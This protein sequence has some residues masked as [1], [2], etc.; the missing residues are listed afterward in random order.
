MSSYKFIKISPSDHAIVFKDGKIIKEGRG[1]RF[2]M[3]PSKQYVIIPA[4][5][6]NIAFQADQIT[7]ENQGVEVTGFAIWK[8]GNPSK[9]YHHFDF[10]SNSNSLEQVNIFLKD[11]VESAIRHMVANMSIEEVLRKRGTIILQLKKELEYISEEWGIAIE[12]IEIKNVRIL[13]KT[14][15][16]NMQAKYRNALILESE[17]STL[18]T[19]KEIEEKRIQFDEKQLESLQKSKKTDLERK[20][21]IELI[22]LSDAMTLEREK[23][24]EYLENQQQKMKDDLLLKLHEEENKQKF[25]NSQIQTMIE[26]TKLSELSAQTE[27]ANK[28]LQNTLS[29]MDIDV[30]KLRIDTQ[31]KRNSLNL[32]YEQLP[33]IMSNIDIKELNL[34][35]TNLE[36]IISSLKS[37]LEKQGS[38][39]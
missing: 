23:R 6:N 35:G 29:K 14:L 13:S 15:F 7:K 28:E 3:T 21:E 39:N 31:N 38:N 25:I 36:S 32:L 33:Q 20:K 1:F 10:A 26:E 5:V 4:V 9:I 2:F 37:Y 34:G 18:E 16:D 12:T 17:T 8:V 24:K 22:T 19:Q 11:V 30:E 27:I